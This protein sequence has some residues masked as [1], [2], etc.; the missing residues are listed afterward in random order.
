MAGS[1]RLALRAG[2]SPLVVGLT[3]VAFGTSS[4]ELVVSLKAAFADAGDL[5]VGNVVGSNICNVLF[6][7]GLAAIIRPVRVETRIARVD[8]P[9][10]VLVSVGTFLLLADGHLGRVEGGLLLA[11]L[12]VYTG[13]ALVRSRRSDA[14]AAD[15]VEP[16]GL[17]SRLPIWFLLVGG[18]AALIL[19][20]EVFVKGAVGLARSLGVSE[21][22][23][24]LTV[25]A[26]GTSLPE[27]SASVLAAVRGRGDLA[28]GNV[29]GS[30]LFNLMGILGVSS[31]VHPIAAVGMTWLD[32]GF[33]LCGA[34]LLVPLARSGLVL[35]RAEGSTLMV[36][37]VVYIVW[38][39]LG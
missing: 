17:L 24:G 23:I 38:R 18:M 22:V 25:V 39:T 1:S 9:L 30:N 10:L 7:L 6:I 3:L 33:M 26:V 16:G 27:L 11:G 21:A 5:S 29:V 32:W 2:I 20:A 28:V 31:L 15:E 4:P 19:G 37:Y 13:Q 34:I 12:A 14:P 35:N 36:A 8:A